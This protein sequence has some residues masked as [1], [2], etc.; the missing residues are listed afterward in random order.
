MMYGGMMIFRIKNFFL[1][2][3][4]IPILAGCASTQQEKIR[5]P[6]GF[7]PNV[8]YAP[9]YMAVEKGYFEK[10]GL[11]IEFDYSVE[12][13]GVSLVGVNELPFAVVSG[14]QVLLA[15]QQGLPVVYAMAWW[16]EYPVGIVAL[17]EAGIRSPEDLRGKKIGIPG[18]FGASYVGLRAILEVAGLEESDV[19]LDSIGFNQI[20][21]LLAGGE[22]AVV[23]YVNNEPIQLEARGYEVDVIPVADYVQLASNGLLTNET[24]I[25]DH[26]DLVR[27]MVGALQK[28]ISDVINDPEEAFQ[29]CLK[30]VD[31]LSGLS[32]EDL[33][34]QKDVLLKS[35][36]FWEAD[37]LGFSQPTAWENMYE[38]LLNM[39]LIQSELHQ[40][41]AYTNQFIH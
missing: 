22:D 15:R 34:I 40:E 5:L 33:Q 20:E 39:G 2:L 31:G 28:G 10:A 24:T 18:L 12:T 27:K 6:M 1:L 29:I 3:L 32:E 7:I 41:D 36:E 14:E 30:H 35:I 37:Q 17:K 38:V 8:Q 9:F 25:A 26:P 21:A 23:I 19:L 11:E 13:N 16:Q 4:F